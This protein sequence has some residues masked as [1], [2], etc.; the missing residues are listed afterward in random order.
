MGKVS[1]EETLTSGVK[2]ILPSKEALKKILESGKKLTIYNG[3]DP[4]GPSLHLGHLVV[5]RKLKDFQDLGHKIIL[6]IGDF[7]AKIGDPSGKISTRKTLTRKEVMN[8]AKDYKEQASKILNFSG[9][10]PAEIKFNSHWLSKLTFEEI[11][12]LAAN[13]TS[14]QLL[15]RDMFQER[16]RSD[17]PIF[18]PELF[19]PLLQGYDSVAMKVD[20]EVGGTD[21][22]F[23]MLVGR[24][25]VKKY[26]GKEKFV[27]SL[28]LLTV[29]EVKMGKTESVLIPLSFS[30]KEMFGK[31]MA[32]PDEALPS[33]FELLTDQDAPNLEPMEAKK[34][35]AR[36]TLSQ[37][38]GEKEAKLAQEEFETVFQKGETPKEAPTISLSSIS[39]NATILEAL[40]KAGIVE[41][42]SEIRRLIIAGAVEDD[43]G[44]INDPNAKAQKGTYKIG[45]YRFLKVTS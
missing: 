34:L 21:Q 25:L 42:K 10:N 37:L 14:Q 23:N 13:F 18:L 26:L 17:K 9:D 39:S 2:E 45:K 5:L 11:L 15:E 3:I 30:A 33:F 6:L 38:F 22:I 29:G 12:K 16:L 28:K 20:I 40:L 32:L 31:L 24:D 27:V 35:L 44:K 1:I 43:K 19:Y 36:E 41:S 7:T 8:N 4:T